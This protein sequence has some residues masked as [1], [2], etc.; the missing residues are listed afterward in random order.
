MPQA[1]KNGQDRMSA[2]ADRYRLRLLTLIAFILVVAALRASYA[3]TMPILFAGVIV[4]ALWPLRVWLEKWLPAWLSYVLTILA[5]FAVMG[6]FGAAIY[7]SL[8]Q[9]IAVMSAQW[10][11]FEQ[12]YT[13]LAERAARMG[14]PLDGAADRARVIGFVQMLA[15]SVYGFVTYTSFIALLVILGLPEVCRVQVKMREELDRPARMELRTTAAAI[16]EQ[17]RRYLSTT[18]ATSLLT[19]LAS[20]AWAFATG[21]DLALV[22]GLLNF[23]LN[24]IPV[25]GNIV[26]IIP[27]VLYAFVQFDGYGMPLLVFVGF[28]ALQIIISNFVYPMLQGRQLS[29]SPLAIVIAMTGWSWV[30]GIAGALIAVP[31]TAAT[32]I[33]CSHFERSRW[34]AKLLST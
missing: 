8:G 10:S 3:L 9:V 14:I 22:W 28:A 1:L 18:L 33:V 24:F 4:A 32:V 26:G 25:I 31:L 29:L 19:G 23:L 13:S 17:V 15:S 12:L 34:I 6:G 11:T 16:S 30:W 21:L 5:L 20:A 7:L 27:P 2:G